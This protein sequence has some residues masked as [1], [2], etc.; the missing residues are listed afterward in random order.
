MV[1]YIKMDLNI[2]G[3]YTGNV[4]FTPSMTDKTINAT[5][6]FF[7]PMFKLTDSLVSEAV[8]E[9]SNAK[10]VFTNQGMYMKL[11]KYATD[12]TNG[13]QKI[14]IQDADKSGIIEDNMKYMIKLWIPRNAS[15]TINN[16]VY[17]I[18]SV[19]LES[20]GSIN[21]QPVDYNSKIKMRVI[22]KERDGMVARQRQ[23]CDDKRNDINELYKDLFDG[24]LFSTA[25]ESASKTNRLA[26][27]MMTNNYGQTT[28]R[29]QIAQPQNNAYAPPG[30]GLGVAPVGMMPAIPIAYAQPAYRATAGRKKRRT[31][32]RTKARRTRKRKTKGRRKKNKKRRTRRR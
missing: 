10:E 11:V 30:Q 22:Q 25:R 19:Q 12:T 5:R 20:K 29:T 7:P 13:Y 4:Q 23:T 24:I 27:T 15:I 32:K 21:G 28:G 3:D 6:I 17:N 18:T 31:K 16:R 9:T 8:T 14:S 2:D 26:P 1:S